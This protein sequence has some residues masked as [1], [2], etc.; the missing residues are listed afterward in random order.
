MNSIQTIR[1]RAAAFVVVALTLFAAACG[2]DQTAVTDPTPPVDSIS[3]TYTLTSVNERPL[4]AEVYA[5]SYLDDSTGLFHHVSVV[6]TDGHVHLGAD[7]T[8]E[9]RVNMQALVDGQLFGHP[10]YSDH[11][12]WRAIEHSNVVLFE[13]FFLEAVGVFNG[14]AN[15]RTVGLSQNL[16]GEAGFQ[17]A[18]FSYMRQ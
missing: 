12:A 5:F 2:T 14:I 1:R 11:G 9:Q 10:V 8:Y 17:N 3:A 4:P 18:E 13:S 6:A 16:T 15:N 7:G